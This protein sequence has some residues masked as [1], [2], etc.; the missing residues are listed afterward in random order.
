MREELLLDSGDSFGQSASAA[1]SGSQCLPRMKMMMLLCRVSARLP[2]CFIC[3]ALVMFRRTSIFT[4]HLVTASAISRTL[5]RC[6]QPNTRQLHGRNLNGAAF[7]TG[8]STGIV[9]PARVSNV[10]Q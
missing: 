3:L 1:L 10:I 7:A 8:S 4:H 2:A 9:F 5:T 6:I